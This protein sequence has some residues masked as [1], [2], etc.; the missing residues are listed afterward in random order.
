MTFNYINP[1]K[2]TQENQK[3]FIKIYIQITQ[4]KFI[5]LYLNTLWTA[6]NCFNSTIKSFFINSQ[7]N[8]T[9]Q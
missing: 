1:N 2:I 3:L 7:F 4:N 9:A 6:I 8:V 5:I